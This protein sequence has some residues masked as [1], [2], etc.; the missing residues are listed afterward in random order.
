MK[1]T[2]ALLGV[3]LFVLLAGGLVFVLRATMKPPKPHTLL[4]HCGTSM[5]K[6]M[7][8]LALEFKQRTGVTIDFNFAGVES[9]YPSILV[10]KEGDVFIC[11]DPFRDKIA[12]DGLVADGAVVGYLDPVVIVPK[13]N[14]KQIHALAD[15]FTRKG[16]RIGCTDPRF[17]TCGQMVQDLAKKH[18]WAKSFDGQDCPNM[19]FQS[20]SH[21]DIATALVAGELDA[22]IVWNFVAATFKDKVDMVHTGETFPETRVSIVTLSCAKNPTDAAAFLKFVSSDI[23]L[24]VFTDEG[25]VKGK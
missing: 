18:G 13:G 4:I 23:G 5:R 9:L 22:G 12:K 1:L 21:A 24:Q 10:H 14:P 15:L 17:A 7:E 3:I 11:H 2:N 6:P 25:Y 8:E 16:L 19:V 20:R